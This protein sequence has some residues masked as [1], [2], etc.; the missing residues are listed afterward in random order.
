MKQLKDTEIAEM[1][2]MLR[3]L[4]N[5]LGS[6]NTL[7]DVKKAF[8]LPISLGTDADTREELNL[9]FDS[10]GG[11][12]TIFQS[13]TQHAD[14]LGQY[15]LTAFIGYGA[16]QQIA[17]NGMI[18]ACVQ[19]VADDVTRKWIE[20]IETDSLEE[21]ELLTRLQNLQAKK[22][23]LQDLFH[24]ACLTTGFMGG[25]FIFIDTGAEG[26]DLELPLAINSKS[27]ELVNNKALKFIVVDPVNV[28][29][30]EYNSIDPLKSDYMQPSSW[31]V[32]GR[33]VHASR[34]IAVY[35]N[36]P[37]TLLKPSY[38]FLGIPQAQ[39]LWDYV[40]HWNKCRISTANLLSK[41]SLLVFQT[42][43]D[44]IFSSAGGL[45]NFDLR[46]E[47]LRKYRDN[48]S[49]VVCDKD[50]EAV[51]NVQTT[52]AGCTDIVRQSLEMIAAINR[53]P[54]VKLLGISPSGFNATGESDIT[55]YYD[56]VH[57]KQ[58]LLRP[59]ITKCLNCIQLAAFGEIHNGLDF[60]FVDLSSENESAQAMTAQTRANML[61]TLLDRQVVDASEVRQAAKADKSMRLNFL[62]DEAPEMESDAPIEELQTDK[63]DDLLNQ[64]KQDDNP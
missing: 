58:E 53:T 36:P 29:P 33:K 31:W 1:R 64:I 60:E 44:A 17:Q 59:A 39:I 20:F 49:V 23:K 24:E 19:T 37:P 16:L 10:A 63:Y 47:A 14:S 12:S 6:F 61:A 48:D 54:A 46:M 41:V 51:S 42:D 7:E 38:N 45:Q 28:T 15:P 18:R 25:A 57:S 52:L 9:A 26:S 27:A 22:F 56:Y 35:D 3:A 55:N 50:K 11:Y 21:P 32:L 34:L 2:E 4:P 40:L 62:S 43:T 30:S 8:S 5:N 13:L